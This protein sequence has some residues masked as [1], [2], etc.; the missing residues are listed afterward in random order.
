MGL[1]ARVFALLLSLVM[2]AVLGCSE[3]PPPQPNPGLTVVCKN[4]VNEDHSFLDWE[5]I[6]GVD[7]IESGEPF[8]ATLDGIAVFDEFF[9]DRAQ[10]LIRDGVKEVNLVELNATVHVRSGATGDDV[11]L[12]PEPIP[13]ECF[14]GRSPCDPANDVLDDPPDPPGLRGNTDCE[15][16]SDVNPCGRFVSLPISTDCFPDGVC[17]G[18]GKAGPDS[19]CDLNAFCVTGALPLRLQEATGHYTA[20]TDKT[21]V[22]FGWDDQSTGATRQEGGENDGTWILPPSIYEEPA[23][24]IGFRLTVGGFPVAL[25]CTMGVGSKGP[26]GCDS[27]DFLSCPTPDSEL[28]SLPIQTDG[29]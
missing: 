28:V 24:P 20:A 13:Y 27:R 14:I 9:L 16:Q 23:G 1:V 8:T 12:K 21:E 17:A 6:V 29:L 3:L 26:L 15:P 19:Q 25:D 2:G 22:L 10:I 11:I 7:S 4:T 18:L 5:L